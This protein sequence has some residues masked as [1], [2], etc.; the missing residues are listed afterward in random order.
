[1]SAKRG[2]KAGNGEGSVF[3]RQV[4]GKTVWVAQVTLGHDSRGKR[5]VTTRQAP[6]EAQARKLLQRLLADLDAGRLTQVRN[7]TVESYGLYW[8]RE[9]KPQQIRPSTASGYE[10]ILRRYVIP[11]L[12]RRKLPDLT[13]PEIERWIL[14]LRKQ[15]LSANT[16]N[17]A[18]RLL[19]GVY[20]HAERQGLVPNNPVRATDPVRRQPG[21]PTQ[22]KDPWTR[23]E[24][25]KV[26]A[27]VGKDDALGC[28]LYLMLMTGLRPGE[29]LGLR[30]SDLSLG[31]LQQLV[32][33]GTLKEERRIMA[34]GSGVVRRVRNEPK[35][36]ASRRRLPIEPLLVK[37][38]EEQQMRQELWRMLSSDPGS[39]NPEGYVIT[40]TVGTPYSASN[41]RKKYY[42][43][44]DAIGVRRIR[45][46]DLRHSVAH[47]TLSGDTPLEVVSQALGH[48]RLDTTKQIYAGYI[49]RYN[50]RFGADVAAVLTPTAEELSALSTEDVRG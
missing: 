28:F 50:D 22:V 15:G 47:L 7:H 25:L 34:D 44:L 24:S 10:D 26:L 17:Q 1:M 20:K 46:H 4:R 42:K 48:T 23:E 30:W 6:T 11:T 45:F 35:T 43:A 9:V 18:R 36:S 16:V 21:E 33:T 37:K 41:L 3:A 12:G 19:F 5:K 40:T 39:W 31:V 49:Q 38:L 29:A 8:A 13:A 14:I 2:H 27:A 32:V